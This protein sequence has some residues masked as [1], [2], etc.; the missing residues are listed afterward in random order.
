MSQNR[1]GLSYWLWQSPT[2]RLPSARMYNYTS[3]RVEAA[4]IELLL[5]S[6]PA[7]L[8]REELHREIGD[9]IAVDDAISRSC[10][11]ASRTHRRE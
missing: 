11:S 8:S 2:E 4:T 10:D 9:R 3:T 7:L 5:A 6:H 1:P